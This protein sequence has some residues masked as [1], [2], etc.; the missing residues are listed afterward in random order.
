MD[1]SGNSTDVKRVEGIRINPAKVEGEI[2]LFRT[3]YVVRDQGIS[4]LIPA[5]VCQQPE[6]SVQREDAV[7]MA[8]CHLSPNFVVLVF[9][10]TFRSSTRRR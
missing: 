6:E 4:G 9:F 8:F 2:W 7:T 3:V 10:P 1:E 5:H